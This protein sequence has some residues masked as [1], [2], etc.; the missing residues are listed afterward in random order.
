MSGRKRIAYGEAMEVCFSARDVELIGDHTFADPEYIR[1][2]RKAAGS[3]GWLSGKFTLDEVD[4]LLGYAAAEANHTNSKKLQKELDALYDRLQKLM[5]SY[6]GGLKI[7]T[8]G[9]SP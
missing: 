8:P 3:G 5:D 2:L 4:D 1:R 6:G 7:S 9:T